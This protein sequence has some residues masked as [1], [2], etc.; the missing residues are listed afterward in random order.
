[1]Y[2]KLL[3]SVEACVSVI[4]DEDMKPLILAHIVIAPRAPVLPLTDLTKSTF[5]IVSS[6]LFE[7]LI[8]HL[9]AAPLFPHGLGVVETL[10]LLPVHLQREVPLFT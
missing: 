6:L 7:E 9:G 4:Q 2:L 3:S 10:A 8:A 5:R 1:M